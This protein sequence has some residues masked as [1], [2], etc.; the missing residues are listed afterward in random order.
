V[1]VNLYD[2]DWWPRLQSHLGFDQNRA[3]V[4][5]GYRFS[6]EIKTEVGYMNQHAYPVDSGEAIR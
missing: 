1:F 2:S 3:F 4:G 6:P 5:L